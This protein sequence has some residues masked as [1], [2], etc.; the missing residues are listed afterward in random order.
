[1]K[2]KRC[3]EIHIYLTDN[4]YTTLKHNVEKSGL[5]SMS[6]YLRKMI[7][8]GYI[9]KVDF[10]N[11][12]NIEKLLRSTGNNVNQIAR[13]VNI[14]GNVYPED[15]VDIRHQLNEIWKLLYEMIGK[16]MK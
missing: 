7:F 12:S 1:M 6:V 10:S 14:N 13:R 16:I 11:L 9:I 4:E 3:R 8:D 5:S 15:L 2:E